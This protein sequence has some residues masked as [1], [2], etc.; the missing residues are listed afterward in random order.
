MPKKR[1]ST[2]AR[3]LREAREAIGLSQADLARSSGITVTTISRTECATTTPSLTTLE[4]LAAGLGLDVTQLL[5]GGSR[6]P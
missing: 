5:N 3:H 2:V 4:A 6:Q 1:T